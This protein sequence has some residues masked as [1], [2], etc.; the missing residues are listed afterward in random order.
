MD[1]LY[2]L[3]LAILMA[4][5]S[6]AGCFGQDDSEEEKEDEI[7]ALGDWSVYYVDTSDG[8]PNCNSDTLG[9]LYYVGSSQSF[10]VCLTSG[11]SFIDLKGNDG[12][13]GPS[14]PAGQDADEGKSSELKLEVERLQT[15]LMELQNSDSN[16][17][18]S[19][20][21]VVDQINSMQRQIDR[22]EDGDTNWITTIQ[23][24]DCG[25]SG[26]G[27]EILSGNDLSGDEELS[28]EEVEASIEICTEFAHNPYTLTN[29]GIP[30]SH[31]MASY[32]EDL[33]FGS[34]NCL[35][36]YHLRYDSVSNLTC[37]NETIDPLVFEIV[38]V[39]GSNDLLFFVM[40][41]STVGR[42]LWVTDGTS[43]GTKLVKDIN[44]RF[45]QA[46]QPLDSFW[47]SKSTSSLNFAVLNE[48]LYFMADDGTNGTELWRSDGNEVGTYIVSNVTSAS[49][50]SHFYLTRLNG[51]LLFKSLD[52]NDE[53]DLENSLYNMNG[54]DETIT[55]LKQITPKYLIEFNDKVYFNGVQSDSNSGTELWITDGTP[56]GTNMVSDI[57]PGS[58]NG[59]P[60]QFFASPN[61]LWFIANNSEGNYIHALDKMGN[62]RMYSQL[63]SE[64]HDSIDIGWVDEGDRLFYSKSNQLR[65]QYSGGG[66]SAIDYSV[67]EIDISNSLGYLGETNGQIYYTYFADIEGR[68]GSLIFSFSG[69]SYINTPVKT[70]CGTIPRTANG[71]HVNQHGLFISL[72]GDCVHGDQTMFVES[73]LY[74]TAYLDTRVIYS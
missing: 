27:R 17:S 5:F 3:F 15:E 28:S 40:D 55:L 51:D 57:Y 54:T 35:V 39:E 45:S 69:E 71:A 11:W 37:L 48:V 13:Q 24:G 74:T 2:A 70:D 41:T 58:G 50:G 8:L 6:L 9:R 49:I 56:S 60:N 53:G 34:E 25:E 62:I 65:M 72:G 59:D 30:A 29:T 7:D 36:R 4:T 14:G 68:S 23:N 10:E 38:P 16:Y 31:K 47:T 18:T 42:E 19:L 1:K 21:Y 66:N 43:L 64:Y 67:S 12:E 44:P 32:G 33:I 46:G 63:E 73:Y 20:D 61:Y 22:L 52:F 26:W